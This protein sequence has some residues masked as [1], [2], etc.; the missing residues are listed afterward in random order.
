MVNSLCVVKR[1]FLVMHKR[2]DACVNRQKQTKPLDAFDSE[3]SVCV[4][5]C[6]CVCSVCAC[7]CVYV[8]VSALIEIQTEGQRVMVIVPVNN[9]AIPHSVTTS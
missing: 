7:V 1:D 9:T 4:S 6:V 3:G 5:V 8:C 2:L